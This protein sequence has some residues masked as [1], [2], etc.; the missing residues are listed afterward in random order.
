[1]KNVSLLA[2]WSIY[3]FSNSERSKNQFLF[4]HNNRPPFWDFR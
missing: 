3:P 2:V 4:Q 1:M